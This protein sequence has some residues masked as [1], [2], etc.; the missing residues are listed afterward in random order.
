MRCQKIK[1]ELIRGALVMKK[2]VLASMLAIACAIPS[3]L[4]AQP[5]AGGVNMTAEEY[6]VYNDAMTATAPADKAAKIEAYLK[7]YPNSAVK[8]D[9]LDQLMFAYSAT[10]DSDK[11]LDAAD[12][13]LAVN[14]NDLFAYVFETSLRRAK[15]DTQT[16]PAAKQAGYD[17]AAGYAQKALALGQPKGIADADFQRVKSLGY[18]V[19]YGAIAVGDVL[20][21]DNAG[22]IATYKK[23]LKD[24][25]PS[26]LT[27]PSTQLQDMFNLAN[28]YYT[29]TPPDYLNC[30]WYATRAAAFAANF[31]PQI[32][33]TA[34]YCY[35]KFHGDMTGYDAMQAAV[36]T[37]V[38]P[39]A[40]FLEGIKPAPKPED[41][42][43]NLIAT[44]PDLA[45]LAI[46]D[47][48]FVLQYGKPEDADKV[49]ATVKG[50][51]TQFPQVTVMDGSTVDTL[52]VAV[53][54]DAVGSKAADFTFKMK[55]PLKEVPASGTKLDIEGTYDSYTQKPMMIMMTDGAVV[56]KKPA[57][58]PP[59]RRPVRH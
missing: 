14:P 15:A 59:V 43:A 46:S 58:K 52:Q 9:A 23:E 22:A 47:K 4:L 42:V 32:Q 45:T 18:P 34:N 25:D 24:A 51:S 16:D 37:S 38:D 48:E 31:A 33:P 30:A 28:A 7:Q 29:S 50:K 54:D 39:P 13:T 36:Q 1:T 53:S 55:A 5:Q 44:T 21:K 35:K 8:A 12:R 10:N 49:F 20:K 26:T 56:E 57:A 6:K 19:F 27:K 41:L 17:D 3:S 2:V 40:G 11:T